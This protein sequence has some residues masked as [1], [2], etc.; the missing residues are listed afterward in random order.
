M[1]INGIQFETKDLMSKDEL[2]AFLRENGES[3]RDLATIRELHF[4]KFENDLMW[5]YPIT[6]GVH[7]GLFIVPVKEGFISLPFS[8]VDNDAYE[9]LEI[10]DAVMLDEDSIQYLIDSWRTFSDDL[11]DAMTDMLRILRGE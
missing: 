2:I 10:E 11:S 7:L 6:D 8:T 1:T 4:E 9:L 5:R 3:D